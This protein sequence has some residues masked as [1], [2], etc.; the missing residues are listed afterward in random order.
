MQHDTYSNVTDFEWVINRLVDVAY[1]SKVNEGVWI[2][3]M[4]MDIVGRVRDVRAHAVRVLEK[5]LGDAELRGRV[6]GAG[7][8]EA[9]MGLML[10]A[11]WVCG[12]YSRYVQSLF[13]LL[14]SRSIGVSRAS[15]W[16]ATTIS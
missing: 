10:A 9:E 2:R 1:V 16:S 7:V 5:V 3:D 14:Q 13:P 8:G 12:E 4:I 11:V 6:G 15:G